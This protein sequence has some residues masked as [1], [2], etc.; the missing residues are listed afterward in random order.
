MRVLVVGG[1]GFIGRQVVGRLAAQGHEVRVP[2]RRA[3]RAR[4]LQVY[5]A[6]QI[7]ECDIHDEP[8]LGQAIDGC[9]AVINLVGILHSAG[10]EP[11][12]P[13]FDRAH[14]QLPAR[15]A[16]A[17]RARDVRRLLHMSA[18]G[19]DIGGP[20][21]YLRSKAAGEQRI[22]D[23]FAGWDEGAVTIF[24]ASVVFGPQDN[25]MNMFARLARMFPVLPIAG[26]RARMHPV[27]VGDVAGARLYG[28][29]IK[30][31][32][33]RHPAATKAHVTRMEI[34]VSD[35]ARQGRVESLVQFAA[36]QAQ[37]RFDGLQ[38]TL[39]RI[40][41]QRFQCGDIGHHQVRMILSWPPL[42]A[43]GK[44]AGESLVKPRQKR[45]CFR[46][47]LSVAVRKRIAFDPAEDLIRSIVAHHRRPA[48]GGAHGT[49]HRESRRIQPAQHRVIE[50][51]AAR[52][53]KLVRPAANN[54]PSALRQHV[55]FPGGRAAQRLDIQ[56]PAQGKRSKDIGELWM[57]R[58]RHAA[59]LPFSS[60]PSRPQTI[61]S[62]ARSA[63]NATTGNTPINTK[64][65]L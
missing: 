63:T 11:W 46:N 7:I 56:R 9:D 53:R 65:R 62:N 31:V 60:D 25:F 18:L 42:S 44:I 2:T 58:R 3:V 64:I 36:D 50:A 14:V 4:E 35:G 37:L 30:I 43:G 39:L 57:L 54:E 27:Y 17:C 19:A 61:A 8:A 40:A 28:H 47:R 1:T 22:L 26:A 21:G 23:A 15:I 59:D 52:I 51:D 33:R 16:A 12:G 55:P 45:A 48:T 20:S 34:A 32:K 41:R 49:G 13:D 29:V 38:R 24:R 10:G 5:P 6:V